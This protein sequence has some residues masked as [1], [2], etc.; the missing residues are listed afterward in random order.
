MQGWTTGQ[1]IGTERRASAIRLPV[2]SSVPLLPYSPDRPFQPWAAILTLTLAPFPC[3]SNAPGQR[4]IAA[5]RASGPHP[6]YADEPCF[7]PVKR[8][9]GA[10]V[11][12]WEQGYPG[13]PGL[14]ASI[15]QIA[16]VPVYR[17]PCG[18]VLIVQASLSRDQLGIAVGHASSS[19][20]SRHC[21][22]PGLG[23]HA[24]QTVKRERWRSA[25]AMA[26]NCMA[27]R[28]ACIGRCAWM[29]FICGRE[30]G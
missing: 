2:L 26:S 7:G 8:F 24:R 17:K 25:V 1:G 13:A 19:T 27:V 18:C 4:S 12:W 15:N 6:W 30:T 3:R 5:M 16:K 21:T 10:K 11:A 28:V 23:S 9:A 22:H 14:F 20:S 29:K